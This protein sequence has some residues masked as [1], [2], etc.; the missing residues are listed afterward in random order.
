MRTQLVFAHIALLFVALFYGGNYLIAKH[1][2]NNSFIQPLGFVLLRVVVATGLFWLLALAIQPERIRRKDIPLFVLC[3]LTGV[4]INQ[5]FF[6][7]GLELT[8]P[9]HASLIMTITPLLVLLFSRLLIAEKVTIFKVTGVII[10]CTGA[11][12]LMTRGV[13]VHSGDGHLAGD[14][15]VLINATSYALYLVLVK[16]LTRKYRPL[17]VIR[18]VFSFGLIF[19]L[20]IGFHQL[21]VVE[22]HTFT[23]HA[24][25]AVA[26]VL[27]CVSFLAYLFNVF[28]LRHVNPS[29]VSIYIYLQPLFAALLSVVFEMEVLTWIKVLAGVLIFIGVALVS[30]Q[31]WVRTRK[32]PSRTL[33]E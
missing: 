29:T 27:I 30:F 7:S 22:W 3:G 11:V 1:V 17:T 4:C 31:G 2:M 20:P 6:F 9:I 13:D 26:Y 28:A 16:R 18:W 8:T 12:L 15:L 25:L 19:V 21:S 32:E 14:A 33:P 23:T 10:G 5:T 24:W